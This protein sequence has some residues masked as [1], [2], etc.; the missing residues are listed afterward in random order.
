MDERRYRDLIEKRDSTGLSREETEELG[1]LMAERGGKEYEGSAANPP[2]DVEMRRASVPEEAI[3]EREKSKTYRDV[4]DSV[5]TRE[6]QPG[7]DKDF[8]PP[9]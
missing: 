8:P 4:D 9:A 5:M 3:E 2:E 7:R 1:K 6:G